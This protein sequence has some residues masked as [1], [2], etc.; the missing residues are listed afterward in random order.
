MIYAK[1][2]G[3]HFYA[4]NLLSLP[5]PRVNRTIRLPFRDSKRVKISSH[6]QWVEEH[7]L[8]YYILCMLLW[9]D[10][11]LMWEEKS[12]SIWKAGI[13]VNKKYMGISIREASTEIAQHSIRRGLPLSARMLGL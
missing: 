12:S 6:F 13:T 3:M 2:S 5:V 11:S 7:K 4:N 1:L 9:C 8:F 10:V